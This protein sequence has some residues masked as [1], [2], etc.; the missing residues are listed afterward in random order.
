[1]SSLVIT[2]DMLS[3]D[4]DTTG[5]VEWLKWLGEQRALIDPLYLD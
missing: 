5:L 3:R 1:M 2:S 4:P